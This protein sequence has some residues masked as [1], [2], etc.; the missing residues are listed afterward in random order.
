MI[1]IKVFLNKEKQ[2][3]GRERYKIN[4]NMKNKSLLSIEKIL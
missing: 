2:Q 3:Y 1:V 4:Q